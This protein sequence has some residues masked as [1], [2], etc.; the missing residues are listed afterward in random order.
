MKRRPSL[1]L[2]TPSPFV[3]GRVRDRAESTSRIDRHNLG[4]KEMETQLKEFKA[5]NFRLKIEIVDLRR[6]R[7]YVPDMKTMNELE[8]LELVR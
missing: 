1:T 8:V 7:Q 4:F 3:I 6:R 2:P 5:E